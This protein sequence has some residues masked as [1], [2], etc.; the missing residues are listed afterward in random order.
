MM[1]VLKSFIRK[2]IYGLKRKFGAEVTY[3][4]YNQ[5]STDYDTGEQTV[6]PTA[7]TIRRCIALPAKLTRE[8]TKNVSMISANKLFAWGGLYDAAVRTFIIDGK[9]MPT[10]FEPKVDDYI[11]YE[12][13][14]YSIKDITIFEQHAG[15]IILA[16]TNIGA[17]LDRIV[18]EDIEDTVDLDSEVEDAS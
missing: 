9:D 2:T 17:K 15:W 18:E 14:K 3:Y 12:G 11:G 4:K 1:S 10:D 7:I 5:S 6:R 8:M 16:K 13:Y